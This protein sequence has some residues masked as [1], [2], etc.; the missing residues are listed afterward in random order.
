MKIRTLLIAGT[1]AIAATGAWAECAFQ[2]DTT[3]KTLSAGFEAWKSVTEAM[4]E[5]GG[6]EA[7]LDQEF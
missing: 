2:N 5:C 3:V 1:A 7:E 4:A 6:V